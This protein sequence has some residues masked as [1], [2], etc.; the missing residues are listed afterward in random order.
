MIFDHRLSNAEVM[1]L[2]TISSQ[3]GS[4]SPPPIPTISHI[5][6]VDFVVGSP[7]QLSAGNLNESSVQHTRWAQVGECG[8]L[9]FVT[10]PIGSENVTSIL[11]FKGQAAVTF[12][13]RHEWLS[14]E[15]EALLINGV[16]S[17]PR[18]T[19]EPNST[20]ILGQGEPLTL[21]VAVTGF[22]VPN[23]R[24]QRQKTGVQQGNDTRKQQ[25]VS[26]LKQQITYFRDIPGA[27][28]SE[29]T[30]TPDEVLAFNNTMIRCLTWNEVS[31][32]NCSG[33]WISITAADGGSSGGSDL[34][35]ILSIT[36]SALVCCCIS[37]ILILVV[38]VLV[39]MRRVKKLM[40]RYILS[41]PNFGEYKEIRYE[42]IKLYELLGEGSF[43]KV[44]R[45]KWRDAEVAVKVLTGVALGGGETVAVEEIRKEAETM[46]RVANHPNIVNFVGA[47][48]QGSHLCLVTE[49]CA[50]GSLD[51]A[52]RGS[53]ALSLSRKLQ[54]ALDAAVGIK[55]LHSE[56]VIHRDIAA[57]NIL[58]GA[59][60]QVFVCDFGLS[61]ILSEG[62]ESETTKTNFGPIPWLAPEAIAE[63]K[64]SESS[65]SFSFG[66]LLW[67]IFHNG[68]MPWG[69]QQALE[70]AKRVA[71]GA[72]LPTSSISCV[73]IRKLV[74][75][76]F[77]MSPKQRPTMAQIISVLKSTTLELDDATAESLDDVSTDDEEERVS[78][79]VIK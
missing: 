26:V 31:A 70:V 65:D 32:V 61:R 3:I 76:C 71:E 77:R 18:I 52:L 39:S 24:W 8:L 27:T 41:T 38:V 22:P 9:D 69:T 34:T 28:D 47:V 49:Y 72:T 59:H 42:E 56:G 57:R 48:S 35:K 44:Y 37:M 79:G 5:G 21:N 11:G 4:L 54:I 73:T 16:A 25:H 6:E 53:P 78:Y 36:I 30:L 1:L 43:G 62:Q 51:K 33:T 7:F 2:Y 68:A 19:T 58:L 20:I 50:G 60:G 45:G 23:I 63:L 66:V 55:H 67:E 12:C 74:D 13:V 64:Y 15:S 40:R 75:Q 10:D 46:T 17:P 14:T 29:F